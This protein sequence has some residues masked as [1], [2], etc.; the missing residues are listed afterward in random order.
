MLHAARCT[1]RSRDVSTTIA[2]RL[3]VG[4]LAALLAATLADVPV[5]AAPAKGGAANLAMI[6]EPQTLDPMAS[7]ADLVSIIMQ[8]VYEPL[9]TFDGNWNVAPMLA[10]SMP[11][12]SKDGLVYTIPLRKG[13]KFHNGKEMTADDVV[14]SLRRWIDMA[15]RGKAVGKEI[16]SLEAKGPSTVVITL[17]RPYAPLLAHFALPSGF[18]VIM[19]KDS[20]ATPLTQFI[21]TGPYMFKERKPDQYVQLVRFDG[22]SARKEPASGYAGK[23]E[24]LLDELRFVP[25][26]N[27]NTRVEGS[28][29]GQYQ[30]ADLLPVESFSRVDGKASVKA[31]LTAP[32]GFP[33]LV[34]N[35]KQGPLANMALRQ[36][37]QAA[38]NDAD[39]MGA[40]FGDP[41][42]FSVEGNHYA[43]GTPFYSTA[44]TENYGK[45]D[46]KKA[47][48]MVAAAKYD[49]T[50]IKI[51]TSQQYD[52]HY[53][54]ALV[55]AENLKAAGLKVDMQVVDWA[56]LIQRRNDPAL[57]DIYITHSAVLPEP[58]LTPPQLGEGAPGWWSS[59]AKKAA[60]DAFDAEVDPAKR[61]PLW[62]KVQEVVY[63]EV[64]YIRV[65]SFN[66]VT[67]RSAKLEGYVVMPYPFFWNTGLGK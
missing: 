1:L 33:Y 65:G 32:F 40:G 62:G 48:A 25:V 29:S 14:A 67:A 61:G 47:A 53:R 4:M 5:A 11:V 3:K 18:A 66:S 26:P 23:R 37:V 7:T 27:A 46:A 2:A 50:P 17:N 55:M 20:I 34:L 22:Y 21:G 63:M 54:I 6:G 43:K 12:I 44:G 51:L 31:M 41:K 56:T 45:G 57:W 64:P 28:L 52:F 38:L 59:P 36:A 13:V 60:L 8:H 10:E 39:M 49:G 58:T 30:F 42:F 9:Y 24:A 15:P 19:E 16:K 35:T